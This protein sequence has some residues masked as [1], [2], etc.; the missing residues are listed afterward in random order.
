MR[1]AYQYGPAFDFQCGQIWQVVCSWFIKPN[2][3]MYGSTSLLKL[4]VS[5]KWHRH[6]QVSVKHNTRH[7]L[8]GLHPVK[9]NGSREQKQN[10]NIT[11]EVVFFVKDVTDWFIDSPGQIWLNYIYA[12]CNWLIHQDR[13]DCTPYMIYVTD[14]FIDSSGQTWVHPIN[15]LCKWYKLKTKKCKALPTSGFLC[16]W[17]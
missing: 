6:K 11:G 4:E 8:S 7:S 1:P 17:C 2:I 12:L 9:N 13:H 16:M 10:K 14:W 3:C 15:A 5:G